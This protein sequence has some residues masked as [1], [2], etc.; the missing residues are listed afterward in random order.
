[1]SHTVDAIRQRR[2]SGGARPNEFPTSGSVCLLLPKTTNL[3]QK[4][5]FSNSRP[6]SYTVV[7]GTGDEIFSSAT[8]YDLPRVPY[9]C[10]SPSS[11]TPGPE[12]FYS[13]FPYLYFFILS[14]ESFIF[15][16]HQVKKVKLK[17]Y[18]EMEGGLSN[19]T[20]PIA[21]TGPT[22]LLDHGSEATNLWPTSD[23]SKSSYGVSSCPLPKVGP[24][25]EPASCPLTLTFGHYSPL[26][27][28]HP[29]LSN[30]ARLPQ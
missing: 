3:S 15:L 20:R 28:L 25:E 21:R 7:P 16:S 10:D 29:S 13:Y 11:S 24:L 5:E 23:C 4:Y 22:L 18:L 27:P 12:H 17:I 19:Q 30:L 8:C 6:C 14:F 2:Y 9:F 26:G 1:M